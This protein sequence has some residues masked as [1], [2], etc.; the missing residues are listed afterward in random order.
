MTNLIFDSCNPFS[1]DQMKKGI[2]SNEHWSKVSF[3]IAL[4]VLMTKIEISRRLSSW[5]CKGLLLTS[6]VQLEHLSSLMFI[7]SCLH[8]SIRM[9]LFNFP[10]SG[11][12]NIVCLWRFD[13]F[14]FLL[15]RIIDVHSFF[16]E[17]SN[18]VRAGLL[19]FLKSATNWT[20]MVKVL[21]QHCQ[22]ISSQHI[23]TLFQK[24]HSLSIFA[25]PFPFLFSCKYK[26][27]H[28]FSCC[29]VHVY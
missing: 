9:V 6:D 29:C 27:W 1:L 2:S 4:N 19:V 3:A 15:Y 17:C 10:K 11:P 22:Y 23:T 12:T 5:I 24:Y 25:M 20:Q 26:N 8:A 14:Y 18:K 7:W 28:I 16:V 21:F 13:P